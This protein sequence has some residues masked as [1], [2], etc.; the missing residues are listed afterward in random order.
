MSFL[1]TLLSPFNRRRRKVTTKSPSPQPESSVPEEPVVLS[2]PRASIT[3]STSVNV[4]SLEFKASQELALTLNNWSDQP[5]VTPSFPAY[6]QYLLEQKQH[7]QK[8]QELERAPHRS[9]RRLPRPLSLGGASHAAKP[10]NS[11]SPL[12]REKAQ[13][14]RELSK[15]KKQSEDLVHYFDGLQKSM[16]ML[17]Q[18]VQGTS[19]MLANWNHV[20]R[21][22]A[23][24]NQEPSFVRLPIQDDK[25][26]P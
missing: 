1:T 7:Q 24:M 10:P 8:L 23:S 19:D 2:E 6:D 9:L 5:V 13:E 14:F 16:Q 26:N 22:M 12:I 15:I 18:D 20:F 17:S 3:S 25:S 4:E 21:I 11:Q